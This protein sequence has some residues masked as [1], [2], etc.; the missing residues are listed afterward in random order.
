M[1]ASP[2]KNG[3]DSL[4]KE[5]RVFKDFLDHVAEEVTFLKSRR[6]LLRTFFGAAFT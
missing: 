1:L 3:L 5:V 6:M 4:F 2:R